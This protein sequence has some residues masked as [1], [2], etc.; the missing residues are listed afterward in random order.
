M[1]GRGRNHESE[2]RSLRRELAELRAGPRRRDRAG[3]N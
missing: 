1:F 3:S 2:L